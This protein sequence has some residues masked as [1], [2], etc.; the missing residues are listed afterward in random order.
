MLNFNALNTKTIRYIAAIAIVGLILT[1]GAVV[2][3]AQT[4]VPCIHMI[5]AHPYGD[6]VYGPYGAYTVP[7]THFVPRHPYGDI[8]HP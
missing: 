7:C 5:P 8:V 2:L 6:I 3:E 1:G 4:V